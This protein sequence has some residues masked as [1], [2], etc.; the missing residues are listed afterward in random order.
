MN[1]YERVFARYQG[2]PVDRAPNFD[3]FMTYA[4]HFIR[5]PLSAY[6]H[7]FRVLSEANFAVQLA[8]DVDILQAI[9]D[10]YRE[11]ADFGAEID[12][13]ADDLPLRRAPLLADPAGL[14]RL[15]RP[16]PETGARMS[17]RLEAVALMAEQARGL[18]P[19]MGW[20]EG[21]LAEA[22]V[23]RGFETV[24]T[25]TYD[26]PEWLAELLERCTE[27]AV[28]FAVAQVEA[29]ADIIGLGDAVASQISP[30]LYLKVA[31]PYEQRI[32]DAVHAAGGV[33][34]LHICGNTTRILEDMAASGAD[35][36]DVDWMVDLKKAAAA[37]GEKVVCGNFDPV[38][39]MLRGTPDQVYQAT[40][41]G[42]E[43]GGERLFS[44]AGCE[45]PDGTPAE[46][47][48]AQRRALLDFGRR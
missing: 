14:A 20:V 40:R 13:P 22:A 32:F 43:Q 9:S 2:L 36:I 21:A 23:L 16:M 27:L 37:F 11:A 34:R 28:E 31:L 26:R 10:P 41:V 4:A 19:V 30:A 7:D 17:D 48:H 33:A 3:I 18:V 38:A 8:F 6:Y 45:I 42:L 5:Q 29:G 15:P 24:L 12:F 47:L 39:V 1:S 46:N 25:D 44:A 35:M